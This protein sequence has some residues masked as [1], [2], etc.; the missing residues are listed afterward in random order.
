M[1]ITNAAIIDEFVAFSLGM[2]WGKSGKA[3]SVLEETR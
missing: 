1:F 2:L 3:V